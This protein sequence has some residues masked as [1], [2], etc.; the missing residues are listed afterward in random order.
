MADPKAPPGGF[1]QGGWYEGRQ[2][3][4]GT[5]SAPGVIHSQSNQQG[6]G[7]SVSREVAAQ[8]NPANVAYLEAQRGV[9]LPG[10]AE[11]VT[12]FLNDFQSGLFN[13]LNAPE[14]RVSTMEELKAELLPASGLPEPLNRVER[15]DELRTSQGVADLEKTLNDLKGQ[16]D[17]AAAQLRI[18]T[19]AERGKPVAQGV[20]EGRVSEQERTARENVDFIQRQKSR[21]TDELNTRYSLI[22][23]Y[24]NLE[25]LDYNDALARYDTEFKQNIEFYNII[26]GERKEARSIFEADRDAARANLQIYMNAVTSGNLSYGSLSGDQQLMLHKLE[27]QS[28]LPMG[29]VANL[30]MAPKDRILG[31]SSDNSQAWIVGED[32]NLKVIQTGLRAS[33]GGGKIGSAEYNQGLQSALITDLDKAANSYGHISPTKANDI[34]S[35]YLQGGGTIDTF[36]E[37]I[38]GYANPYASD[39]SRYGIGKSSVEEF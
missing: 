5:F 20:I 34:K 31:M 13:G 17:E 21:I 1:Q 30:Q 35:L 24:M 39:Y 18:N 12:P 22:N 14:T 26:A 11:G 36:N 7:Q 2:Y 3:W 38:K 37:I 23:T 4:N 19:A 32:G 8:T 10:S 6:A 16:E 27:V 33:G 15:F 28:G 25:G 9:P 29:F